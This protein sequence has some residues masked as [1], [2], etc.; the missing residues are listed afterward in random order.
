[1]RGC[2][3]VIVRVHVDCKY[4]VYWTVLPLVRLLPPCLVNYELYKVLVQVSEKLIT[5][6]M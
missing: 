5:N 2:V 6:A 1:M 4:R 3:D